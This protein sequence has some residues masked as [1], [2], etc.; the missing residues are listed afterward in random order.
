MAA[1]K[2]ALGLAELSEC[3]ANLTVMVDILASVCTALAERA[4]IDPDDPLIYRERYFAVIDYGA[5]YRNL[6]S[7]GVSLP[8]QA[9]W[10]EAVSTVQSGGACAGLRLL[11][12]QLM[13]LQVYLDQYIRMVEAL[14]RLPTQELAHQLHNTSLEVSALVMGLVRFLATS[15][16]ISI[17]CGH[18]MLL[19]EQEVATPVSVAV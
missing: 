10:S 8:Q 13:D 19:Y 17:L 15:T 9:F 18:S 2:L 3:S 5:L 16:Y 7:R 11:E 4:V 14:R 1:S 6:E 12:R